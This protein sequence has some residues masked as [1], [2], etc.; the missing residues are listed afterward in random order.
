M[1]VEN[2]VTSTDLREKTNG[3][4]GLEPPTTNDHEWIELT[5]VL[6]VRLIDVYVLDLR[7]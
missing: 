3:T 6:T 5:T 1:P 7:F 2:V 4:Q